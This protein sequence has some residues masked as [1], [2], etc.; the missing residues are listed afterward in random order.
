[1]LSVQK[2]VAYLN[3]DLQSLSLVSPQKGK[4]N[5]AALFAASTP[6]K[7]KGEKAT[8]PH[9][10]KEMSVQ[11]LLSVFFF[12]FNNNYN[13]STTQ[14]NKKTLIKQWAFQ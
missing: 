5:L 3:A 4:G 8:T 7:R 13:S 9:G 6:R 10:K 14:D 2:E 11:E 12:F 1:L